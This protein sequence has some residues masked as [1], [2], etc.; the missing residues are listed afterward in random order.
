MAENDFKEPRIPDNYKIGRERKKSTLDFIQDYHLTMVPSDWFSPDDVTDDVTTENSKFSRLEMC[1]GRAL[2]RYVS[3]TQREVTPLLNQPIRYNHETYMAIDVNTRRSLELTK[4]L[5]SVNQ[6][7]SLFGVMNDTST[8]AGRRLLYQR[9]CAPSN[10]LDVIQTR[11]DAV[12][13]FYQNRHVAEIV[14]KELRRCS[15]VERR[16]QKVGFICYFT[17]YRISL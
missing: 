2:L 7:A 15:D 10:E 13:C 3:Y 4:P 17:D 5:M 12:D 11:L 14:H 9:I 8:S 16:L 1:A 6:K